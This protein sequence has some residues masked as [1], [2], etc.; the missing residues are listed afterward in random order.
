MAALTTPE[1]SSLTGLY[2]LDRGYANLETNLESV[3]ADITR[4]TINPLYQHTERLA[5]QD[6]FSEKGLYA[7]TLSINEDDIL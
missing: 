6:L 2:Y 5:Q 7:A 1:L 4:K 3:G